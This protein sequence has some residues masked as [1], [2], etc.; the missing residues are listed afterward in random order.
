MRTIRAGCRTSDESDDV[1]SGEDITWREAD[2]F[3]PPVARRSGGCQYSSCPVGEYMKI[4]LGCAACVGGGAAKKANRYPRSVR[5]G[6]WVM[7][8]TKHVQDGGHWV[9]NS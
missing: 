8:A 4:R 6:T 1:G 7:W 3:G 5:F 2:V 9:Q